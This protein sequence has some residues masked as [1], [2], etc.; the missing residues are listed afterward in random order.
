MGVELIVVTGN[1][2]DKDNVHVRARFGAQRTSLD[3]NQLSRGC[4]KVSFKES[5]SHENPTRVEGQ[6]VHV[7][8]VDFLSL[9]DIKVKVPSSYHHHHCVYIYIDTFF[10]FFVFLRMTLCFFIHLH[11]A[12]FFFFFWFVLFMLETSRHNDGPPNSH[13]TKIL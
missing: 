8:M 5:S 11:I 6:L 4:E 13:A 2:W 9:R 1:N 7:F 10:F 12:L 3:F